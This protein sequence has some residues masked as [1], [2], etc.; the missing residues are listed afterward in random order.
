[1]VGPFLTSRFASRSSRCQCSPWWC[2]A[3]RGHCARALRDGVRRCSRTV[4][5]RR[6]GTPR[7]PRSPARSTPQYS[8]KPCLLSACCIGAPIPPARITSTPC[9]LRKPAIP[10]WLCCI[11][12]TSKSEVRSTVSVACLGDQE[13]LGAAEM[14]IHNSTEVR[15]CYDHP[16][17]L[18]ST[19]GLRLALPRGWPDA[20]SSTRTTVTGPPSTHTALPRTSASVIT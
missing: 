5:S 3:C 20:V 14:G 17:L 18:R 19:I 1:M 7:R 16:L 15:H 2:S 8:S 13:C 6:A 12:C 11:P 9:S 10:A 4:L